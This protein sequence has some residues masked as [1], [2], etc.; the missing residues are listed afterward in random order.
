MGILR[1]V[2]IL[3]F[4][5]R[6]NILGDLIKLRRELEKIFAPDTAVPGT[7]SNVP[8]AGHCAAVALI[9]YETFGG[10]LASATVNGQS[11]WFNLVQTD[12]G[13]CWVDLT[14]DQFGLPCVRMHLSKYGTMYDGTRIRFEQEAN[15]ETWQRAKM[16]Y[17]R[18]LANQAHEELS[19]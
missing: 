10:A 4:G 2:P 8:S 1:W 13:Q 16:L 3:S 14:A 6:V 19:Q 9:V 7:E 11:H 15:A 12:D 5:D 18:L 17:N